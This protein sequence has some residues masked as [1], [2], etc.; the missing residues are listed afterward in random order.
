VFVE[1]IADMP[2]AIR[3]LARPGD[4]VLNMGAGSIGSVPAALLKGGR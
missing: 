1:K 3:R 4:V 2:E